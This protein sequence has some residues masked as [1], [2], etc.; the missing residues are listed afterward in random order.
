MPKRTYQP[1][2]KQRSEH[3]FLSR[4]KTKG[5]KNVLKRR[6][7]KGRNELTVHVRPKDFA[8]KT[9]IQPPNLK[10]KASIKSAHKNRKKKRL[11]R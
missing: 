11:K 6:R 1:K 8:K 2:K 5:G 10:P 3:G 4:S 7:R 9:R